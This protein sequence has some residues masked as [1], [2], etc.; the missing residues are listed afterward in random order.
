MIFCTIKESDIT[1]LIFKQSQ[2]PSENFLDASHGWRVLR[3]EAKLDFSQTGILYSVI[4]PL[5]M[6]KISIL[7]ISTFDTD[8]IFFKE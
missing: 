7:V 8:Y 1:T 6:A 4:A 3:V 5:S 2:V